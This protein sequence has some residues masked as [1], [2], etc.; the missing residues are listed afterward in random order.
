MR[1][2][3]F[4]CS[5]LH[6]FLLFDV[7]GAAAAGNR[8][9]LTVAGAYRKHRGIVPCALEMKEVDKVENNVKVHFFAIFFVLQFLN[10]LRTEDVDILYAC[11]INFSLY[12][13]CSVVK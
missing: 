7:F 3:H 13:L 10:G 6:V 9:F 8:R 12:T 2:Q 5:T 4:A 11:I 1:S